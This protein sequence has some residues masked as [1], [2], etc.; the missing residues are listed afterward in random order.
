LFHNYYAGG[1]INH[2][3]GKNDCV[4]M[5]WWWRFMGRHPVAWKNIHPED[6]I[7]TYRICG[8][9]LPTDKSDAE[10]K[11]STYPAIMRRFP[12]QYLKKDVTI[13]NPVQTWRDPQGGPDIYIEYVSYGQSTQAQAGVQ[14]KAIW[15]DEGPSVEFYEEQRPR[16]A[17]AEQERGG[18]LIL[19]Y[20]PTE[21]Q[22]GWIFDNIYD[23]AQV[24]MRSH[25]VLR[26][27]YARSGK[28]ER[29]PTVQKTDVESDIAV[30]MASTYD[31][32]TFSKSTV[33]KIKNDY[34]DEDVQDARIWGLFRQISG[35]V[36][37]NFTSQV[38]V[39]SLGD[40][41][42][43]GL[44]H[45]YKFFRG[46]D[47]HSKNPWACVWLALSPFNELF[48]WAELKPDPD[49]MVT[50]DIARAIA[51]TSGDYHYVLSKIDPYANEKQGNT[52]LSTID[53]LNRAFAQLK[54]D[55]IGSG[56]YWT[57]WD[58]KSSKGLEDFRGRLSNSMRVGRP[59]NNEIVENN[60]KVLL[61][62]IWF[63]NACPVV[64]ESM[65]KWKWAEWGDRDKLVS[66]DPKGNKLGERE[67][68]YSHFPITIECLLKCPELA[69]ARFRN[70]ADKPAL[71]Q[72]KR[73]FNAGARR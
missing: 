45:S 21:T 50:H 65:K 1:L 30:I 27:I 54:R 13:R 28:K 71:R 15:I 4:A 44:P 5:D 53:D 17:A 32:P 72:G 3:T 62:T 36:M 16:L 55:G 73:Y 49:K 25:S 70:E 6:R 41:F 29:Y 56:G 47:Y 60:Q 57:P 20:T 66:N 39:V 19:T 22:A 12:R 51:E 7:R 61:P 33:D 69:M 31:N 67:Q 8:E 40:F 35:K 48:V 26:R 18:D 43:D 34:A 11:C 42:P 10:K 46:V 14:R 38:H 24:I 68:R 37:K 63:S 9:V 52:G 59:F 23:R 58:T 64:I 2:N